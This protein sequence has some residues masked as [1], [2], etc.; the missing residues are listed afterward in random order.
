M[1]G[2]ISMCSSSRCLGLC[3]F[4]LLKCIVLGCLGV[5]LEIK[6]EIIALLVFGGSKS[7]S[8]DVLVLLL[9]EVGIIVSVRMAVFDG[10]VPVILP[11]GVRPKSAA[12]S[13][14]PCLELEVSY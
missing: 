6:C 9:G 12:L 10:V 7:T 1:L 13:M 14:F 5:T 2:L 11:Y 3:Q 8:E 4:F